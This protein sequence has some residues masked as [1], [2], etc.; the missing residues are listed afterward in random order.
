MTWARLDDQLPMHPKVRGL[1]DA[2]FRLYICAICWSNMHLSDGY[3]PDRHLRYMSDVRRPKQC[4]EQLVQAE[5]WE[6]TEDGWRIHDY[7][8]YQPSADRVHQEREAKQPRLQ[9]WLAK[10][11]ASRDASEEPS[12]DASQDDA[13]YPSHPIPSPNGSVGSQPADRNARPADEIL[14]KTV[15]QTM[16]SRTGRRVTSEQAQAIA[17]Q[18]IGSESVRN[19]VSYVTAAI[20]RDPNPRRFLPANH[21]SARTPAEAAFAAGVTPNGRPIDDETVA[22]IAAQ[23][24]KAL[25]NHAQ[26]QP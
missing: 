20:N 24:R 8:Q 23:A 21:P 18:I 1:T 7:L 5:L 25:A 13:P 2:A 10:R 3:I 19:P 11:D 14:I 12:R 22:A 9:R 26:D 17:A 6:V 15:Q 4:A 16:T